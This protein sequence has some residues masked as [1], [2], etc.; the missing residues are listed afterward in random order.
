V[1]LTQLIDTIH[2]ICKVQ[3]SNPDKKMTVIMRGMDYKGSYYLGD[4]SITNQ[5]LMDLREVGTD[6]GRE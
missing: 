4:S 2:N 6:Q 1:S 3:G 5:Y